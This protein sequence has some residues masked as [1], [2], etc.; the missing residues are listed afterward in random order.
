MSFDD[1]PV[2]A[3]FGVMPIN[4]CLQNLKTLGVSKVR[5]HAFHIFDRP[6]HSD[7]AMLHEQFLNGAEIEI[8]RKW[9]SHWRN[10]DASRGQRARRLM[11]QAPRSRFLDDP[12][13]AAGPHLRGPHD[14]AAFHR[15]ASRF[16]VRMT[17]MAPVTLP[18]RLAI[19]LKDQVGYSVLRRCS[20]APCQLTGKGPLYGKFANGRIDNIDEFGTRGRKHP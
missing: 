14:G 20:A 7:E 19:L 13:G 15:R 5:P 1:S 11:H 8:G 6:E 3:D 10:S 12:N 9:I 16:I 4:T 17:V 18:T 2:E